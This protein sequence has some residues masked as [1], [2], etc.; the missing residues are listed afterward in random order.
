VRLVSPD[1]IVEKVAYAL[2]NPVAAGLV[3]RAR[4]GAPGA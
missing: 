2:A 3:P 4:V 1:D